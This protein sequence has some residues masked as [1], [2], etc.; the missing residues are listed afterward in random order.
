MTVLLI[1]RPPKPNSVFIPEMSDLLTT[2]CTTSASTII[3]GDFNIDVDTPSCHSAADFLQL[4][5]S[6]NLQPRVDSPTHSRG[7]TLDLVISNSAPI[8]NLQVYDL[9]VSD[10]KVVSMELP[11]PSTHTKPKRQ[12]H[13]RNLKN[14]NVDALVRYLQLLSSGSTDFIS[15]ADSMDF[16]TWTPGLL[17]LNA[18]LTSRSVSFL[19][20]APWFTGKLRKMRRLGVSLGGG[21]RPLD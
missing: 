18:P 19:C 3:L 20:S 7:H 2:L 4:L 11:F 8:S 16:Y 5:D 17:D 13:F 21:S 6:L 1:Y 14:I 9:D 10:D 12:I 15:A